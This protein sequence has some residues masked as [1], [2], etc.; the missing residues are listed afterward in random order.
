MQKLE[1]NLN[2]V[3]V[4]NDHYITV[5]KQQIESIEKSIEANQDKMIQ[6]QVRI[7]GLKAINDK[8]MDKIRTL[9]QKRRE[10]ENE[11]FQALF[12]EQIVGFERL[13]EENHD[14]MIQ[15]QKQIEGLEEL[16]V[17]HMKNIRL[18]TQKIRMSEK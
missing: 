10:C 12:L 13:I 1:E 15:Y 18:L 11:V 2:N 8:N 9:A 6:L 14:K 7:D 4:A 3:P 17:R 5:V 16:N